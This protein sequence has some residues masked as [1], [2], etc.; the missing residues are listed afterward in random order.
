MAGRPGRPWVLGID[1]P[2]DQVTEI[3]FEHSPQVVDIRGSRREVSREDNRDT[4]VAV[5]FD[6]VRDHGIQKLEAVGGDQ[7]T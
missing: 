3:G 2:S 5:Q 1:L 4:L 7:L 6:Q